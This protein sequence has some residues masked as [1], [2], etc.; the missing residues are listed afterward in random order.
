MKYI[1]VFAIDR[2]NKESAIETMKN[3][4]EKL[5]SGISFGVFAEGTRAQPNELLPFKK[6]AFYMAIDTGFPIVPVVM[7][8]TD[9]EMGKKLNR[10]RPAVGELV[11]L[12]PIKTKNLSAQKDLN[13]LLTAAR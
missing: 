11:L 3:A 1:N 10:A 12:P 7:K 2:T 13:D 9:Y 5:R 8:N 4:A 6:G